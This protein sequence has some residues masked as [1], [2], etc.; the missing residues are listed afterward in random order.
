LTSS[1]PRS[2]YSSAAY[3]PRF[4]RN[5]IQTDVSTSTLMRRNFWPT[6]R[7]HGA[8]QCPVPWARIHGE[9]GAARTRRGE[10]APRAR[11]EPYQC[12]S[13]R[14]TRREPRVRDDH[15]CAASSSYRRPCHMYVVMASILEDLHEPHRDGERG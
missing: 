13:W 2:P 15:Q 7:V 11:V 10:P 14:P 8:A 1:R 3:G 9:H 5:R 4:A 12:P 6:G